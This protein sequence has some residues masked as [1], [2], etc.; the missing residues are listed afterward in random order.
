MTKVVRQV[1]RCETAARRIL[2]PK[3]RRSSER[4]IK[5]SEFAFVFRKIHRRATEGTGED[6]KDG[7]SPIYWSP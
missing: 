6:L 4:I 1:I 7:G 3:A 5:L 2:K